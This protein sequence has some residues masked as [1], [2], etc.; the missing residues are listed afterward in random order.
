MDGPK[1]NL[2]QS[3]LNSA[4]LIR[5]TLF[6]LKY[7]YLIHVLLFWQNSSINCVFYLIV[8]L[9]YARSL[10]LM[11]TKLAAKGKPFYGTPGIRFEG[12]EGQLG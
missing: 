2:H 1:S 8:L 7:F 11:S 12:Y 9:K 6:S 5:T 4:V 10:Y 3:R